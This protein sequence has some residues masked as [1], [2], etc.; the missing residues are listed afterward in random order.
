MRIEIGEWIDQFYLYDIN[1]EIV[2]LEFNLEF[3]SHRICVT[4]YI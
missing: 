2:L 3:N 4:Q 1:Y